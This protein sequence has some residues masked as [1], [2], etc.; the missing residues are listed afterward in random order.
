MQKRNFRN[1]PNRAN[2][3]YGRSRVAY[4][5]HSYGSVYSFDPYAIVED[6]RVTN[7]MG[8]FEKVRQLDLYKQEVRMASQPHVYILDNTG[9]RVEV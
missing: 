3:N 2:N 7:E 5:F 8:W 9:K 4:T 1:R 6:D